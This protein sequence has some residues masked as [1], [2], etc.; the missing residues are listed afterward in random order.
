MSS[1][2]A[3]KPADAYH[4][5]DLR[6]ALLDAA[7]GVLEEDPGA[8]LSMRDLARR[9]GVSHQA[10]YHYFRDRDALLKALGD[11]AIG[12]LL[13]AQQQ[14]VAAQTDPRERLIAL[15]TAYVDFAATRPRAFELVFDARLCPPDAPSPGRAPL[16]RA[17][18]D[19]LGRCIAD[20]CATGWRPGADVEATAL[21]MWGTAHGLASLVMGGHIPREAIDGVLRQVV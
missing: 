17:N 5:G 20:L 13:A 10:P 6:R 2:P 16:I 3:T 19:L 14:A 4:H 12:D 9:L 18:E 21:A 7:M 15:G 8:S 1:R 11:A